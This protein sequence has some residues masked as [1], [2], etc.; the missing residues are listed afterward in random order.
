MTIEAL[1]SES[2]YTEEN[3]DLQVAIGTVV[4]RTIKR[5]ERELVERFEVPTADLG[6]VTNKRGAFDRG[7]LPLFPVRRPV[8]GTAVTVSVPDGAFDIIKIGIHLCQPGDVLV[9][10]ARGNV[11][12]ALLGGN[13]CRGMANRGIEALIVDGAVRDQS[14]IAEDGVQV[15]ARGTALIM[16][17][18]GLS[19]RS[20]RS[21]RLRECGRQS[22]RHHR[23]GRR[24][25]HCDSGFGGE[26]VLQAAEALHARHEAAQPTLLAGQVTN[27]ENILAKA[28]AR[29]MTFVDAPFGEV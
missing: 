29:G 13:V 12:H 27:I 28:E 22:R 7:I 16:G 24:R 11:N 17:H 9:V 25:N 15:F 3:G 1:W 2:T 26:E 10:N 19:R 8:V 5:P 4:H 18:R 21:D 20:Q 6:D 23:G 14:E